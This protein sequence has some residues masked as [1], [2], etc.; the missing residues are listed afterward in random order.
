MYKNVVWVGV[1]NL[2]FVFAEVTEF[3]I[4]LSIK[5]KFFLKQY[6]ERKINVIKLRG[7]FETKHP[8]WFL[9][10][11]FNLKRAPIFI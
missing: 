8:K 1:G 9:N 10:L 4:F 6:F 5:L 11:I 3:M 2:Q 7:S